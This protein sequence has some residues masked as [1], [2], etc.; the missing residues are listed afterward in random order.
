VIWTAVGFGAYLL[1]LG[2][3]ALRA[4]RTSGESDV[5]YYLAGRSLGAWVVALSAVASGRS[6]WLLLGMTWIAYEN[7]VSAVWFLP[8]YIVAE[9]LLFVGA[10]RQLRRFTGGTGDVTVGDFF[11]SRFPDWGR[12]LRAVYGL[13]VVFFLTIYVASQLVGGGKGMSSAFDFDLAMGSQTWGL[14]LGLWFTAVI[15]LVYVVAGGFRAVSWTDVAQVGFM[16]L[17]LVV[18][19]IVAVAQL[20]GV[21]AILDELS[22]AGLA[23]PFAKGYPYMLTGLA[24]GL[25]S[26]GNPHILVRYMSV[27]D[28]SKLKRA[29]LVGTTWNV[30]MGWGALWIGLAGRSAALAGVGKET[31]FPVLAETYLHPALFGLVIA[32]L[33]AAIMSTVDSQVLVIASAL[34]R[35]LPALLKKRLLRGRAAATAGK[36]VSAI[37]ILLAAFLA[38][39]A[40]PTEQG[41][42]GGFVSGLVNK[43]VL[44]AWGGLG[45]AIGPALLLALYD[46]RAGGAST[47]LAMLTGGGT[48]IAWRAWINPALRAWEEAPRWIADI[49]P[50]IAYELTVAFPLALVTGWAAARILGGPRTHNRSP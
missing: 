35:D 31:L 24:V 5:E 8:G 17:A 7:G 49:R 29:A 19:P 4:A 33:L 50:W 44:F 15:V 11:A 46:R 22:R 12:A 43:L 21:G 2:A 36:I 20:G 16:L 3:L 37:L 27:D 47:F 1:I 39:L 34:T 45:A 10:G 40:L 6:A 25:G 32:A 18:L 42:S 9:L 28:E 48:A 13:C 41:S 14:T 23:S 38:Q 30:I 26:P